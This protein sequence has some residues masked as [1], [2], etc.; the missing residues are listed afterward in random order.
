MSA[1]PAQEKHGPGGHYS[2]R[3]PVPNIQRFIQSLD[4]DKKQRDAALD[5]KMRTNQNNSEVRE[6]QE[7]Q[8]TGIKGTRKTVTD[9]TTGNEVTIEDVD[10]NFMKAVQDPVVRA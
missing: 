3:N 1:N 9:P 6:H 8:P 4:A 7:G 10:A 2:S 5:A